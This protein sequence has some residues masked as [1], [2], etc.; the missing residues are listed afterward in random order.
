MQ[1]KQGALQSLPFTLRGLLLY[2]GSF[3]MFLLLFYLVLACFQSQAVTR[4]G[5]GGEILPGF[6][7]A[8]FLD[9]GGVS[10]RGKGAEIL[11][12]KYVVGV[13][14]RITPLPTK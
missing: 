3:M 11:G 5:S 4:E 14:Q 13:A 2:S 8:V 6:Q 1:L 12:N 9:R 10:R 7:A